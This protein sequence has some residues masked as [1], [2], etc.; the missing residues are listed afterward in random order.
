MTT[1][2]GGDEMSLDVVDA[3]LN[4]AE[5]ALRNLRRI[6]DGLPMDDYCEDVADA[7]NLMGCVLSELRRRREQVHRLANHLSEDARRP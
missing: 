2:E 5:Y 7:L 3:R 1:T 4:E 6:S